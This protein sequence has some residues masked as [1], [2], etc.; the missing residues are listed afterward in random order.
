VGN[1]RVLA[2]QRAAQAPDRVR[3]VCNNALG[4][5]FTQR[6]QVQ[7]T[8]GQTVSP[9]EFE[10]LAGKAASK[11]WKASIRIDKAR[12][13]SILTFEVIAMSETPAVPCGA[14]GLIMGG[15]EPKLVPHGKRGANLP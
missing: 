11:K 13:F 3:V 10:R 8:G 9:T 14:P 1:E 4:T 6:G 15:G 2:V 5:F 12:L 7:M